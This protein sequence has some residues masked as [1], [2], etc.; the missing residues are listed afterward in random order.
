MFEL[1]NV[2]FYAEFRVEFQL[3]FLLFIYAVLFTRNKNWCKTKQYYGTILK[4]VPWSFEWNLIERT[5]VSACKYFEKWNCLY[6]F[7][8]ENVA[9][10]EFWIHPNETRKNVCDTCT[11]IHFMST[12]KY[13]IFTCWY[14]VHGCVK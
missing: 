8:F 12:Y 14:I 2:Y 7:L 13:N 1:R 3:K 4:I 5:A 6:C 11:S 10:K 9:G